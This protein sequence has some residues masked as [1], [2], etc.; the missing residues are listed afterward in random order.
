MFLYKQ[1]SM[2]MSASGNIHCQVYINVR[3]KACRF[4][5]S[6]SKNVAIETFTVYTVCRSLQH[7]L[8]QQQSS[9]QHETMASK[10]LRVK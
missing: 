4:L 7:H 3:H 2:F 9:V 5:P 6:Y 10:I 1:F 8:I